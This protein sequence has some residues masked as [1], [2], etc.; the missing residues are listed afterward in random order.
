MWYLVPSWLVIEY[1][2]IK[3]LGILASGKA[4]KR[5]CQSSLQS[6]QEYSKSK[7]RDKSIS[8][9]KFEKEINFRDI[10]RME[11][12][13]SCNGKQGQYIDTVIRNKPVVEGIERIGER[14]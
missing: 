1:S 7:M 11:Y 12:E 10:K 9:R 13:P 14:A 5:I 6:A 8:F 2:K 3:S 4:E